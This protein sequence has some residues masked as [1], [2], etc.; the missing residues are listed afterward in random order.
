M[1]FLP[2]WTKRLT[3]RESD[4]EGALAESDPVRAVLRVSAERDRRERRRFW[5]VVAIGAVLA[6]TCVL[7][8]VRLQ[9]IKEIQAAGACRDKASNLIT[10]GQIEWQTAFT[11]IQSLPVGER[12]SLD[13]N[14]AFLK[15][16]AQAISKQ[17]RGREERERCSG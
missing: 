10:D 11:E 6:V 1:R 8:A 2:D 3:K 15:R 14:V 5:A 17:D 7:L 16:T 12:V 13:T 4:V 9:S